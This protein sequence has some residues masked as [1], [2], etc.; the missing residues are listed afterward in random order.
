MFLNTSLQELEKKYKTLYQNAPIGYQSLDE[1]GHILEVNK[2]WFDFFG[3]DRNEVIGKSFGEFLTSKSR[4][5]MLTKFFEFKEKGEIFNVEFE[6]IKKNGRLAFVLFNGKIVHDDNRNFLYTYCFLQDITERKKTEIEL[7][8]SKEKFEAITEQSIVSISIFQG[9]KV[10]YINRVFTAI[11]GYS[12]EV[13][14]SYDVDELLEKLIHF[15]DLERVI[16]LSKKTQA[17]LTNI[18]ENT[19][20]RLITKGGQVRH[21]NSFFKSI[22][23]QGKSAVLN[24]F[25]D[26]TEY[27]LSDQKLKESEEKFRTIAEESMVGISIVQDNVFKYINKRFL[28]N[29][30][31]T[32]EEIKNWKPN[33]LFDILVHPDQ[34]EEVRKL[35]R[36]AQSGENMTTIHKELK[37]IRKNKEIHWLDLYG[38]PI[39]YQNRPAGMNISIDI[40]DH[41]LLDQQL[42]E[43]EKKYRLIS[44]N[45]NDLISILND[46]FRQEYI[47]EQAYLKI[48]GYSKKDLIG[49][50]IWDYVHPEDRER[51]LSSRE[52]SIVSFQEFKGFDREELRI[53]HKNGHYLWLEYTSKVFVDDQGKSKAIIIS[54]DI[55]ERKLT[56]QKLKES[57]EKFRTIAEESMVGIS[58]IQ[59]DV[60]KYINQKLLDYIGYTP[61]EIKKWKPG[62]LFDILIHPDQREEFK[63]LSRL[64]QT[65]ENKSTIH[66]EVSLIR[67]NG[68]II[69]LDLYGRSIIYQGRTAAMS[70]SIDITDLKKAL[71]VTE[72][73][74]EK[75]REIDEI[76]DE[77][78][79]RISHELKTPLVSIYSTTS[80]LINHF[81]DLDEESLLS[82]IKTIYDGGERLKRLV[83]NLMLV[84]QIE[85]GM[86]KLNFRSVNLRNLIENN[87]SNLNWL[88]IQRKHSLKLHMP[89]EIYFT[90][91]EKMMTHVINNLL[92]NAFKYTQHDGEIVIEL[93][94][95]KNGIEL[96]IKDTGIGF[97]E[98][99]KILLFS[100]F[101]K[102]ERYGKGL[103][104]DIEGPGLGLF[105]ADQ[106]V[107]LHDGEL[108][109]ESD[110]RNKGSTFIVRLYRKV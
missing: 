60:F 47:N 73:E 19:Q 4:E 55:T 35:S 57:E 95:I 12:L 5:L 101:G 63:E 66:I 23:Y 91:D 103:D 31:Y 74:V 92:T 34:R 75:L 97:S 88:L 13:L 69:F 52:I 22:S 9:D 64:N 87:I 8:E 51:M 110:G 42:E 79:N 32:Y 100:R 65:G 49:K 84:Y 89:Q 102:I 2:A 58:I 41:K 99:E 106:I 37:I 38:R 56:E 26:I 86:L 68:E 6:I 78:I 90:V 20:F 59:N 10:K 43:S 96:K 80:Y 44:E 39:I 109:A 105:I 24:F 53:K 108:I 11:S 7:K 15:E 46:K 27:I 72:N 93:Y 76:K 71:K 94:E 17:G 67:K 25:L 85:S 98:K 16:I 48:L 14:Y 54:R 40:T 62:E 1:N 36:K 33:E 107:R 81:N 3:Y 18:L 83:E 82:F 104:V 28:D 29:A 70:I 45:A 61:E 77:L 30:G 21:I 50:N